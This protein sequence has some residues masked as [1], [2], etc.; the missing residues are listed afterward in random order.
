MAK[1]LG[2]SMMLLRPVWTRVSRLAL[3]KVKPAIEPMVEMMVEMG[4]VTKVEMKVE[5][6]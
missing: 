3:T 5:I 2:F 4:V 6:D 1:L